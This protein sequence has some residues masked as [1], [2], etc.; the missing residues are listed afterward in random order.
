MKFKN[1]T[2]EDVL[3][4]ILNDNLPS[5]KLIIKAGEERDVPERAIESAEFYGLTPV[6]GEKIPVDVPEAPVEAEESSISEMKVET[7]QI[8]GKSK[9]SNKAE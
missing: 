6:H 9:K 1:E 5:D 7:K 3:M 2:K 4:P 8:K